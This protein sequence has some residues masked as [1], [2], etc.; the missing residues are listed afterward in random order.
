MGGKSGSLVGGLVQVVDGDEAEVG[1]VQELGATLCVGAL[2]ADDDRE[3]EADFL[4]GLDDTLGNDVALHDPAKDVGKDDL[5][6]LVR[7]EDLEGGLDLLGCGTSSDVQKVGRLSAVELDLVH[8]GHGEAGA[9]DHARDVPVQA[10]VVEVKLGGG[11]LAR[12]DLG[13]V[14][15][16]KDL[17]LAE[18]G[19]VVKV[20]LG[21][22]G[23]DAA[24]T[25]SSTVNATPPFGTFTPASRNSWWER[26][27]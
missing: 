23:K 8:S 4:D 1:F 7:R 21:V 11:D 16:V 9:V 10:D 25:A 22:H 24:A 27:S 26:C 15:Q 18:G 20:Q 12:V 13:R 17:L 14:L 2:E 6:A 5:D 3:V 19:V